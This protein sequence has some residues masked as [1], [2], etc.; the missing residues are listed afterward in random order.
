V[1]DVINFYEFKLRKI[2]EQEKNE[3]VAKRIERITGSVERLKQFQKELL[4]L[5]EDG[6]R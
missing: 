6:R 5:E 4:E 3:E 1:G 2:V